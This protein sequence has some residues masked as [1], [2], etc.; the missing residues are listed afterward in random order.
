VIPAGQRLG[1]D[2]SALPWSCGDEPP[3]MH[4]AE[5]RYRTRQIMSDRHAL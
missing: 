1:A 3:G 5:L 2:R 4:N